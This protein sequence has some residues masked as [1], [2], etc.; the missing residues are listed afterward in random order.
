VN[1]PMDQFGVKKP[2]L[3]AIARTPKIPVL[4]Q[5]SLEQTR[6]EAASLPT[7]LGMSLRG[8]QGEEFSAFGV[9]Q[10]E[11]GVQLIRL[12]WRNTAGT[13]GLQADDLV[14]KINGQPV[15]TAEELLA[16]LRNAGTGPI[17]VTLVRNQKV[18][19]LV[20]PANH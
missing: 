8:L 7:W 10:E 20:I 14:Q 13:V 11:G 9:S 16:E 5:N 4:L 6:R 2:S 3:K 17:R 18:L 15:R 12:K 1:F 19:E